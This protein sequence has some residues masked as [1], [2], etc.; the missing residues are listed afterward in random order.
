MKGGENNGKKKK[1]LDLGNISVLLLEHEMWV[2]SLWLIQ[3][4]YILNHLPWTCPFMDTS[5]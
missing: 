4:G 2:N 1:Q 5:C 3:G